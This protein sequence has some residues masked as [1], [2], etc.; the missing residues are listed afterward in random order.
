MAEFRNF[1]IMYYYTVSI[2]LSSILLKLDCWMCVC[3]FVAEFVQN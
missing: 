1:A 3:L 2:Y